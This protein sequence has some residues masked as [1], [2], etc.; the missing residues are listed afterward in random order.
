MGASNTIF[1]GGS[2]LAMTVLMGASAHAME[3]AQAPS[4]APLSAFSLPSFFDGNRVPDLKDAWRAGDIAPAISST[5]P[6]EGAPSAPPPSDDAALAA[7]KAVMVRAEQAGRDA[8]A[9]RLKAE[10]LSRRFVTEG[11]PA[12]TTESATVGATESA[13]ETARGNANGPASSAVA[14][15]TT[16][17]VTPATPLPPPSALGV[18]PPAE[19]TDASAAP[20]PA[21]SEP[22]KSSEPAEQA[23][24]AAAT[25]ERPVKKQA[26]TGA[27]APARDPRKTAV[28]VAPLRPSSP[29]NKT[30]AG[31]ALPVTAPGMKTTPGPTSKADAIP[32]SIGAF[33]WDSQPQ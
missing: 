22:D 2:L 10:E 5:M 29:S 8:A 23:S 7:A 18:P 12:S 25:P 14:D 31:D 9:V 11:V 1:A 19:P 17:S 3:P 13:T 26:V 24:V 28:S 4:A 6:A 20:A 30:A 21:T 32:S 15:T 16:G 27:G 33:G